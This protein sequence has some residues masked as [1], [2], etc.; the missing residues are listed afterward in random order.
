MIEPKTT[1]PQVPEKQRWVRP[2][3]K[4]AGHAGEMLQGAGSKL[5]NAATDPGDTR[6]P[7]GQ[8]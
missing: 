6:K 8:G 7:T 3:L 1:A 4:P 5:S 2:E